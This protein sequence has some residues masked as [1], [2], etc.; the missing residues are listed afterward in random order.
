MSKSLR[1]RKTDIVVDE[2]NA[3]EVVRGMVEQETSSEAPV[4]EET[5]SEAPV[6]EETSSEAPVSEE[7]SSEAPVSEETSSEEF[8]EILDEAETFEPEELITSFNPDEEPVVKKR[9][10]GKGGPRKYPWDTLQVGQQY[11]VGPVKFKDG[12]PVTIQA[13]I[14]SRNSILETNPQ[15]KHFVLFVNKENVQFI[16]CYAGNPVI[17]HRAKRTE[18]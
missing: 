1:R 9:R 6:S 4:S 16:R 12:K 3:L 7:T 5:S 11:K 13:S 15:G 18:S 14:N 10:G 8:T 2:A 17:K